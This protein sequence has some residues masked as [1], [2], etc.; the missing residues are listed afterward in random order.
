MC[1]ANRDVIRE[2]CVKNDK[3]DLAVTDHEK[4]LAWQEHYELLLNEEFAWN[5]ESLALNDP[6]IGPR[7]KI[8][9]DTMRRVLGRMK[10]GKTA[11]SSGVVEKCCK[12]LVK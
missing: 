8:E 3:G 12:L 11:G 9:V 2:K 4:L 1:A 6:T 10:C 7:P 5:K